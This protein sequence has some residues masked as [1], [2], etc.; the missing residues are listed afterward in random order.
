MT[1]LSS[2]ILL[3]WIHDKCYLPLQKEQWELYEICHRLCWRELGRLPNLVR[4]SDYNDQIQWLK[5]FDQS[6]NHVRCSDKIQVRD[7]VKDQVGESYLADLYDVCDHFEQIDFKSLP[8]AFVLKTNHDSGGVYLVRDKDN[9]DKE[10]AR[11]LIE[12]NL[13]KTYGWENG[14]WAY[15]FIRPQILVE[16]FVMP[17]EP[18]PPPDFKF[19]CVDGR[20]GWL[21]YIY[22]RGQGTKETIVSPSGEPMGIH[23]DHN[24]EHSTL[25]AKPGNWNE[26]CAVA[27][28]LSNSWKYVRIDLFSDGS[29]I[30]AGEMTFFPLYGCYK[31]KGQVSLGKLMTFDRSTVRKP[32]YSSIRSQK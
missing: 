13:R 29:R 24:M 4:P 19:H 28:K 32:I 23:F 11:H 14:E 9:F 6:S 5:L 30:I 21:Q 20:I 12:T 22:D 3:K 8:K 17:A 10:A 18:G 7:Y 16:E 25:F 2:K 31:S 1:F 15:A 27:E 26:L